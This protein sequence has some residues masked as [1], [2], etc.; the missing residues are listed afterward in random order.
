MQMSIKSKL[1]LF[2]RDTSG[3]VSVE[4]VVL[5]AAVIGLGIGVITIFS[6]GT[7][8]AAASSN[9]HLA[10]AMTTAATTN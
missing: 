10:Q 3:A 8:G 6:D 5:S 9:E 2:K 4:W 1:A 7:N